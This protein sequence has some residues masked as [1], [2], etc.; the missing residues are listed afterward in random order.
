MLSEMSDRGRQIPY[1][2]SYM[3]SENKQTNRNRA[4]GHREKTARG[5]DGGWVK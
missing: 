3:E 1:D 5:G 4:H 2:L